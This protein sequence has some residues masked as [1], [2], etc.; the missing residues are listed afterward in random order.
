VE[1]TP[2]HICHKHRQ[3]GRVAQNLHQS[4]PSA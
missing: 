1:V 3:P 2:G 4:I